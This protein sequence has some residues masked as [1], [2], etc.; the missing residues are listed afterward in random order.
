MGSFVIVV[1]CFVL[2]L[3]FFRA[4]TAAYGLSQARD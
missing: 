4:T 1:F 3:V 2:F